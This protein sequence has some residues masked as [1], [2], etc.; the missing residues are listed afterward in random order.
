M[1]SLN[2]EHSAIKLHCRGIFK[3]TDKYAIFKRDVTETDKRSLR[4][5]LAVPV[6][7]AT[8][9]TPM[10][11]WLVR[12]GLNDYR[13]VTKL[14]VACEASEEI[15]QLGQIEHHSMLDLVSSL[16]IK[17][18]AWTGPA[19]VDSL[20]GNVAAE[21]SKAVGFLPRFVQDKGEAEPATVFEA[22]LFGW[23]GG[24]SISNLNALWVAGLAF[25]KSYDSESGFETLASRAGLKKLKRGAMPQ[26]SGEY[27]A[28]YVADMKDFRSREV[29]GNFSKGGSRVRDFMDDC[30]KS[31]G[32]IKLLHALYACA[33]SMAS[34]PE[35]GFGW[36]PSEPIDLHDLRSCAIKAEVY[37]ND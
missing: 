28:G 10:A 32:H 9:E 20:A 33:K 16:K 25:G 17:S 18:K 14:W 3:M 8:D 35:H 23:K 19:G 21:A 30:C 11:E 34:D 31:R 2:T 12:H 29:L 7:S 13:P 15:A 22:L 24:P 1:Q 37:A 36:D 27:P 6:A 26:V 5:W 4:E